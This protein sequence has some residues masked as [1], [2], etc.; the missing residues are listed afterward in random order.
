MHHRTPLKPF[1]FPNAKGFKRNGSH[2]PNLSKPPFLGFHHP[3]GKKNNNTKRPAFQLLPPM[4]LYLLKPRHL[5]V[6]PRMLRMP[7]ASANGGDLPERCASSLK[8][9][10]YHGQQATHHFK[11]TW[12]R[13]CWVFNCFF[14]RVFFPQQRLKITFTLLKGFELH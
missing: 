2:L 14:F 9:N 13:L 1:Q 11:P 6:L 3:N 4:Q 10:S 5:V 8:I 7:W 12:V